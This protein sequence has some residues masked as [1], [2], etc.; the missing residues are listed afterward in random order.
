MGCVNLRILV[1]EN[2]GNPES[3]DG[4]RGSGSHVI[5]EYGNLGSHVDSPLR[6]SAP[7]HSPSPLRLSARNDDA[8]DDDDIGSSCFS[9]F[10]TNA[11][12]VNGVI[13]SR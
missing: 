5:W 1:S 3:G 13:L 7:P 9:K 4:I 8:D 10:P 12:R 11:Q 2:L 6:L